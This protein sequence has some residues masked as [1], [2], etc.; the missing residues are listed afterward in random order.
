MHG[1][2]D[3]LH[4]WC[5]P[6][7]NQDA[8]V[9]NIHERVGT[10]QLIKHEENKGGTNRKQKGGERVTLPYACL[11]LENDFWD[12]PSSHATMVGGFKCGQNEHDMERWEVN[13]LQDRLNEIVGK[14]REGVGKIKAD[15]DT[16]IQGII[17]PFDPP[18]VVN[19]LAT[20]NT[21]NLLIMRQLL[22][23]LLDLEG[24]NVHDPFF[25]YILE[26]YGTQLGKRRQPQGF[27]NAID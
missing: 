19:H 5:E 2:K 3:V 26:R 24:Y 16:L 23:N 4:V 15:Q 9:V 14:C 18:D 11:R 21:P 12:N 1:I 8:E 10:N 13:E 7:A 17:T 20:F 25:L 6:A 27:R 22:K